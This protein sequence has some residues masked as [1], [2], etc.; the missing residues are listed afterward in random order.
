MGVHIHTLVVGQLQTNCHLLYSSS[1]SENGLHTGIIVDPGDD[2]E[3]I[4][5]TLTK[6]AVEPV[7]IIATHGHFD[8]ITAAA[9]LQMAFKI[10]FLMN[11]KDQFLLDRMRESTI[12]FT[13]L[14]PGPAPTINLDLSKKNKIVFGA[15]KIEILKTPGHTPGSICLYSKENKILI[16]G[17]LIFADDTLGRS[18][19]SYANE[20]DLNKSVKQITKLPAKTNVYPGHGESFELGV[21]RSHNRNETF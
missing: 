3:Y 4:I 5:N 9:E 14:D 21:F 1:F 18:D 11:S 10:P 15:L 20:K 17:D 6:I 19:F 16:S 2:S 8:H 13:K 12:H 7:A